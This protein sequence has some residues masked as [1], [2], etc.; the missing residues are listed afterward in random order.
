MFRY[1]SNQ[2]CDFWKNWLEGSVLSVFPTVKFILP[3][4]ASQFT[5]FVPGF[6]AAYGHW[7]PL[8]NTK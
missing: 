8:N 2:A 3:S 4:N 5:H 7:N 6:S 1:H